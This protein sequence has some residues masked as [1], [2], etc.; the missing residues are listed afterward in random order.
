VVQREGLAFKDVSDQG[1]M[2]KNKKDPKQMQSLPGP[3][4]QRSRLSARGRIG[5]KEQDI[6][7]RKRRKCGGEGQIQAISK[8]AKSCPR[9]PQNS[10]FPEETVTNR[11]SP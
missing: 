6:S 10:P 5:S 8:R 11:S 7:M 1:K 9:K 3:R 4:L 2:K